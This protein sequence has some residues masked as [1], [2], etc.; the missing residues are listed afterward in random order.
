MTIIFDHCHKDLGHK[1]IRD[2][3]YFWYR[4]R[5]FIKDPDPTVIENINYVEYHLHPSFANPIRRVG[6]ERSKSNFFLEI[7][8]ISAFGLNI[9]IRFKDDKEE[10]Q[11]YHLNLNKPC[12]D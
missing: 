4:F 10:E 1:I 9:F 6:Q 11:F 8:G 7:D 2:V 3:D 12:P 5:I